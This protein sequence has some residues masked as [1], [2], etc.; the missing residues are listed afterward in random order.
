LISDYLDA[1]KLLG[2]PDGHLASQG[3]CKYLQLLIVESNSYYLIRVGLHDPD[4]FFACTIEGTQL[5]L[6]TSECYHVHFFTEIE[7]GERHGSASP[8]I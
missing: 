6:T 2:I 5:S 3:D 4:L 8:T 7:K 1:F